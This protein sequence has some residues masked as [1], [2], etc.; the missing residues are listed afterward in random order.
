MRYYDMIR[1][2]DHKYSLRLQIALHAREHGIHDAARAFECT[3]DTV[4]TWLRRYE[5][6][7]RS[8]LVEKSRAP[9]SCPHKTSQCEERKV[10]AARKQM[11]CAGPKRLKALFELKPSQGA[12]GRILRQRGLTKKRRKKR[13]RKN[14]LRAIKARYR[15]FERLQTDTKPLYDIPAYWPQMTALR[16]PRQQYTTRDVKSGALFIDYA[17]DLSATYAAMAAKRLLEHLGRAGLDLAETLL[18]TDN[19]S[20]FGGQERRTRERGFP[21]TVRQ[22]GAQH[23]F[24]PPATPNAHADVESSHASIEQELFDLERFN[25]RTEFFNKT[26]AFQ[27]WWNFA[28]PNYSKGG[29]T[30]VQIL[31]EEGLDPC[32]LLLDPLDLDQ[33]LRNLELADITTRAP[34]GVGQLVP[35]LPASPPA[36]CPRT[37]KRTRTRTRKN[38]GAT[39]PFGHKCARFAE[40]LV[41]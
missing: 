27:H 6:G 16:L 34:G 9:K 13:Q 41:T 37:R 24:L 23:R 10:L 35:A 39:S 15:P 40:S 17:D 11:P 20:E 36:A 7:G 33:Q 14:D 2:K 28:R 38:H 21:A 29:K 12:I 32:L 30:P 19:G 5:Q 4:R 25:S 18:S 8:A 26:R 3:R 22:G 1:A 31:K